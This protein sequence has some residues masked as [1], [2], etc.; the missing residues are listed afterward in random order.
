MRRPVAAAIA[1]LAVAVTSSA[2]SSADAATPPLKFATFYADQPGADLPVSQTKLNREYIQ[3]KNTTTLTQSL[4]GYVIR[5]YRN[6]H[7]FG[8]PSTFKLGPGKTVTVHTGTGTANAANLYW[9]M[10][11]SYVWN[12][13]GDTARLIKGTAIKASCTYTPT[14]AQTAAKTGYRVC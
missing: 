4:S 1:A 2:L 3:V 12:N 14:K 7:T 5:D 11:K 10:T 9:G 8:F 6:L 13:T